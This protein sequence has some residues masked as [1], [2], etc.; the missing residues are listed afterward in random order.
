MFSNKFKTHHRARYLP[1][2]Y[3]EL[4]GQNLIKYND[5]CLWIYAKFPS[6]HED[7]ASWPHSPDANHLLQPCYFKT[8][9]LYSNT[10]D[11]EVIRVEITRV[12]R[13][14]KYPAKL[15]IADV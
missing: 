5:T 14:S 12:K 9:T 13:T 2:E 6:H 11:K 10:E 8:F 1:N 4:S 7:I 15:E 3:I